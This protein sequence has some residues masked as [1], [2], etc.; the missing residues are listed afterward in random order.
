MK[1]TFLLLVGLTAAA[2]GIDGGA[3]PLP[4]RG[5]SSWNSF[6]LG[7]NEEVVRASARIMATELLPSGYE[8]LLID[9]GWPPDTAHVGR[10]PARDPN[11]G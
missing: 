1:T 2:H 9:D 4:P 6:G 10:G 7:I 11:T 5:W 3:A 8:Y